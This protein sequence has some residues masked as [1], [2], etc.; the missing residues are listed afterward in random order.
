MKIIRKM[1]TPTCCEQATNT[2]LESTFS[3]FLH[4]SK[5]RINILLDAWTGWPY[6]R[7]RNVVLRHK[8]FHRARLELCYP[9]FIFPNHRKELPTSLGGYVDD[10]DIQSF[11]S[12]YWLSFTIESTADTLKFSWY[13]FEV[14]AN[15]LT[16]SD[17]G[18]NCCMWNS[19][20]WC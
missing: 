18:C 4:I 6:S 8:S 16:S 3:E 20:I 2:V 17:S 1:P 7:E 9:Q 12:M 11:Y 13:Y 15:V 10:G 14:E 5:Q 19:Y